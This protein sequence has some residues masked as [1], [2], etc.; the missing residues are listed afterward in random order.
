MAGLL[1]AWPI[2]HAKAKAPRLRG[3]SS[4]LQVVLE[5][6]EI[7]A[8]LESGDLIALRPAALG[9]LVQDLDWGDPQGVVERHP[10]LALVPTPGGPLRCHLLYCEPEESIGNA[11]WD[12]LG[13]GGELRHSSGYVVA[14]DPAALLTA[15]REAAT[16]QHRCWEPSW[17]GLEAAGAASNITH[18]D[19]P[20]RSGA[21]PPIGGPD[22]RA[23]QHYARRALDSQLDILRTTPEGGVS[24]LAGPGAHRGRNAALNT[25]AFKLAGFVAAGHLDGTEV[26]AALLDAALATGLGERE[27][28]ATLDSGFRAGLEEPR[29]LDEVR[30][31]ATAEATLVPSTA[32]APGSTNTH[33][34]W[35]DERDPWG[36]TDSTYDAWCGRTLRM[37]GAELLVALDNRDEAT[38]YVDNGYGVWRASIGRLEAMFAKTLET[39]ILRVLAEAEG[40]ILKRAAIFYHQNQRRSRREQALASATRVVATWMADET[41]PAALTI[42]HVDELDA[43]GRYLGA[44]NGIVDLGSGRLLTGAPARRCLC[45]RTLPDPYYP[46][47]KKHPDVERLFAHVPPDEREWLLGALGYALRGVPSRRIYLL[48]G[49]TAGGKSTLF[50]AIQAALGEHAGAVEQ[51]TL[52]A[53]GRHSSN[54]GPTPENERWTNRRLLF[55]SE[56]VTGR[57]DWVGLKAKSGGDPLPFRRL[58]ENYDERRRHV[59]ATLIL[60]A[61]PETM[62]VPPLDDEALY[63]RVRVLEYPQVPASARDLD[64]EARLPRDAEARQA[65]AALLIRAAVANPSPPDDVP[66][67]AEARAA[68]LDE[69]LGEAGRWARSALV[70]DQGGVVTTAALWVA[71]LK[72]AGEPE[73]AEKAWGLTRKA[74]LDRV[75]R[76]HKLG[77]VVQIKRHCQ[78]LRGWR[79][80]KIVEE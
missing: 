55:C 77:N 57:L 33:P 28:V 15:A 79:G 1:A 35:H 13:A 12:Y 32:G 36:L 46:G 10:P 68:L 58:Y 71:A 27:A 19:A 29:T 11:S 60:A 61:N 70:P 24:P 69:S 78:N 59:T 22:Q 40:A 47:A 2:G 23:R 5:P 41:L 75:K 9:L 52:L 49:P 48:R 54:T 65:L 80:L 44:P 34:D 66:S 50:K 73:D 62:P 20:R 76:I 6:A 43:D 7:E 67:V 17:A 42:A 4:W 45:T 63:E 51:R 18:L 72:A 25:S 30:A 8:A 16:G 3:K 74:L 56:P 38:L 37:F 21:S 31:P 26:R 64:L 53:P 39:W 14:Y